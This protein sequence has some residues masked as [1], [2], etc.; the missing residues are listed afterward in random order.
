MEFLTP[1]NKEEAPRLLPIGFVP[2][3]HFEPETSNQNTSYISDL[4]NPKEGIV[5]EM[6]R[7][8]SEI[9]ISK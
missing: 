8:T 2:Q 1:R 4:L 6:I 3:S 7:R 5:A 9:P